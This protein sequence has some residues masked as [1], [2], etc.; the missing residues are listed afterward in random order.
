MNPVSEHIQGSQWWTDY[1]V[2][3]YKLQ[4]KRGSKEQY[5]NM[6]DTCHAAGVKVIAGAFLNRG[7]P[8]PLFMTEPIGFPSL[9]DVIFNH[10]AGSDSGVGVAGSSMFPSRRR[11]A[12]WILTNTAPGF[13]HYNY[14]GIY[15]YQDFH[16]CGTPGDDITDWGNRWQ[17]QNCELENLAEYVPS[18]LKA[19]PCALTSPFLL[20]VWRPR[21]TTCEERSPLTLTSF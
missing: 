14:P 7:S 20:V 6:V 3:S 19:A 18:L 16:H 8:S 21:V 12:V 13:T 5:K 2:A 10:M 9:V 15:Q 11:M 4:S 17:V 1:Q